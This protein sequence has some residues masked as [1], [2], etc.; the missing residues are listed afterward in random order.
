MTKEYIVLSKDKD[1]CKPSS[2]GTVLNI[3][4]GKPPGVPD[5]CLI[6]II[7]GD[8]EDMSKRFEPG[9]T[10]DGTKFEPLPL[11]EV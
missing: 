6:E 1:L 7:E 8:K 2:K 5:S 3:V 9:G 10:F 4:V 11:P